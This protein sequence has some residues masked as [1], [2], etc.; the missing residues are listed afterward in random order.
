MTEIVALMLILP[1]VGFP[2]SMDFRDCKSMTEVV[3]ITNSSIIGSNSRHVSSDD[4]SNERNGVTDS[5]KYDSTCVSNTSSDDFS[6]GSSNVTGSS[7]GGDSSCVHSD[8]SNDKCD[9]G[10]MVVT[11]PLCDTDANRSHDSA[12]LHV[13]SPKNVF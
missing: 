12:N 5:R 11:T 10:F 13:S 2:S 9:R 6:N 3:V 7:G 4:Y 1:S 8:I